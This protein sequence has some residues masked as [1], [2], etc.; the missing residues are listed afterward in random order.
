M[1]I[2][3]RQLRQIIKEEVKRMMNEAT[4]PGGRVISPVTDSNYVE[5]FTA[6]EAAIED[7]AGIS[8]GATASSI[9]AA[10]KGRDQNAVKIIRSFFAPA[11]GT[12]AATMLENKGYAGLTV[13]AILA[14]H[15][16]N[17]AAVNMMGAG[18]IVEVEVND[19]TIVFDD[20]ESRDLAGS[21]TGSS[22][23]LAFGQAASAAGM[24]LASKFGA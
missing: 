8:L 5:A 16:M 13:M 23:R 17:P 19:T 6:I 12:R 24:F 21:V 4:L 15:R 11:P 3:G 10:V 14:L 18:N 2:T 9:V 22:G 1:R 7:S 20:V